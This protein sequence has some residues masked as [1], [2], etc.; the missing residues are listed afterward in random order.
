MVLLAGVILV[1]WVVLQVTSRGGDDKPAATPTKP[2]T[3]ITPVV[4]TVPATPV[5]K[6]NGIVDVALVRADK[7]CD[8]VKIRITPTVR[9]GQLNKGPVDIGLVVSSSDEQACT[10]TPEVADAIAVISANGT[11]IWDSTVCKT[12][13][14]TAPI[15]VSPQWATL[16]TVQWAGRGSGA[17]CASS[18]GYATAGKY[19]L[20]I[21]TLGGEP[22]KTTFT[23]DARP[24]PPKPAPTPTPDPAAVPAP[25]VAPAPTA[26]APA[27]PA[28]TT[29]TPAAG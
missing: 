23:L 16:A 25:E 14:L 5:P 19:T 11:A 20:Q 13:L 2:P 21:G 7:P 3:K 4:P 28:P 9:P 6:T 17:N 27:A 8:P 24:A 10:L 26:A 12:S 1:A 15:D 18:E 29:T 22:G